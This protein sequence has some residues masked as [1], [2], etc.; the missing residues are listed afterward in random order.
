MRQHL[1]AAHGVGPLSRGGPAVGRGQGRGRGRGAG[2]GRGGGQNARPQP[3]FQRSDA[4]ALVVY[5]APTQVASRGSGRAS[6][7]GRMTSDW[8]DRAGN[9]GGSRLPPSLGPNVLRVASEAQTFDKN[10]SGFSSLKLES[11]TILE[12]VSSFAGYSRRTLD[13]VRERVEVSAAVRGWGGTYH[14]MLCQGDDVHPASLE[15]ME[16]SPFSWTVP[17]QE[18]VHYRDWTLVADS[19]HVTKEAQDHKGAVLFRGWK[20]DKIDTTIEKSATIFTRRTEVA[21][22][23]TGRSVQV[24]AALVPTNP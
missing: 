24:V 13:K 7:R 15:D 9:S 12:L 23:C 8:R 10:V 14:V 21:V 19:R 18:G 17:K 6:G 16:E 2:R 11:T 3:A 20:V 1:A 5:Q 22:Q 4:G